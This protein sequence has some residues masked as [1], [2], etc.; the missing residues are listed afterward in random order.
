MIA[1]HVPMRSLKKSD[2]A[3]L[4]KYITSEQGK[5]ERLGHIA[6]TN[7]AAQT[8]NAVTAEVMATQQ[9]NTRAE[10]DKTYHLLVSFRAGEKPD[11]DTLRA[12]EERICAGLGFGEHQR[13]SAI[14]HDTDNLHIHIAIN[15]IHPTRNTIHEPYRAYRSLADLCATMERDYGLE[16]DNHE[17]RKH[18]SENRANDMERHAGVE[19]L[20]GW[21]KRECL[22]E[23]QAAQS[24]ADLHRVLGENGLQIRE[25]ANGFVLEADD[26]TQ[27]KA[28]TVSRALSKPSLEARLGTFQQAEGG[29]RPRRRAYKPNPLKTRVDTTELHARYRSERQAMGAHRTTEMHLIR[30]RKNRLIEDAKRS[31]R[32]R[33]AA[34]KLMGGDRLTKRLLYAQAHKALRS[35]ME[36]ISRQYQQE[37]QALQERTQR[38]AW[39][40][41]LKAKALA[42]D[43]TALAA[44]RA[45]EAAQGLKGDT[46]QGRG[47]PK[48]GYAPVTDNITKKGTI[49][50][51]VGASA[52]RD[53]GDRLQVS[54]GATVDGLQAALS[55][56]VGRYGS[57]ISVNGTAAFKEQIAQAAVAGNFSVTFDDTALEQRRQ[58]LMAEAARAKLA[59]AGRGFAGK[60]AELTAEQ[61]QRAGAFQ[62][63]ALT[64]HD[65]A[66]SNT[67]GAAAATAKPPVGRV[68]VKPPPQSQHR[69]RPLSQLGEIHIGGAE[70]AQI[71]FTPE[72]ARRAGAFTEEALTERDAAQSTRNA[73]AAVAKPPVGR[74]GVKPPPQSQH[75]LRPLS[76]LDE[77]RI[78]GADAAQIEFAPDQARRAGAFLEDALS[79]RDAAQS[80]PNTPAKKEQEHEQSR[81]DERGRQDRSRTGGPRQ[82]G[83]D[84]SSDTGRRPGASATSGTLGTPGSAGLAK[85]N[86]GR[87][88]REPPPEGQH[89]LRTLPELGVVRIASGSEVLL[90]RDVPRHM[91]QQ[92][93]KPADALRRTVSGSGLKTEQ[94]AAANKYVAEREQKRL[95]GFDIPKH[96]R[97]TDY[98]GSLIYAGTRTVE[99]QAL[100]LL[101]RE[102]EILVM[103]VDQAT[104]QR[105][106]RV[107]IGDAISVTARG[108]IKTTRGRSR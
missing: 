25:R 90:P 60:P 39:A 8:L 62:E 56:A 19:S 78:G 13:V 77:I 81:R 73:F 5:T 18:V 29:V 36:K 49:I 12:I 3:G 105:M 86:V 82:P 17:T 57:R 108:S 91:E 89:R 4:V 30:G 79:E 87:I 100:A 33:R 22:T 96:A 94:V 28:S 20:V 32:L 9:A 58:Q 75:R 99:G 26:G 2:F 84:T 76:Q 48:P 11:A 46:I 88:G 83:G 70:A 66:Q 24:W 6:V 92:V 80:R 95:N 103:P 65:A 54:R 35:D 21:V 42:G 16:R 27:A 31:N 85:P 104:A 63:D 10:G 15:K 34:I 40:D 101:K 55:L 14:H 71:E 43:A 1:K 106:K 23:I 51:R 69:L 41:W 38:R 52:V 67:R 53:D 61:A 107:A 59:E 64:E 45:R 102:D 37:R 98:V 72:Q 7:C 44:L 50:Y 47:Q 68:G 93:S 74:V 97:Y